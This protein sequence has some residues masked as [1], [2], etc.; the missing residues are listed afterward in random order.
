M[1]EIE[2]MPEKER[3]DGE[4]RASEK[5]EMASELDELLHLA[6][7]IGGR[8]ANGVHGD[9]YDDVRRLNELL[10]EARN[11]LTVVQRNLAMIKPG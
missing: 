6:Q 10:H 2:G 7:E 9:A 3:R 8:L 5:R 1:H 11:Q 4:R